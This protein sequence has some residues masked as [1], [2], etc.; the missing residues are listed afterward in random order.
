M[1][2]FFLRYYGGSFVGGF[3]DLFRESWIL[4]NPSEKYDSI[5][6]ETVSYSLP[7]SFRLDLLV[8][9]THSPIPLIDY[10][11]ENEDPDSIRKLIFGT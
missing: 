5:R 10:Q 2:M 8:P 11:M 4:D 7:T 9:T 6:S 3:V 1:N